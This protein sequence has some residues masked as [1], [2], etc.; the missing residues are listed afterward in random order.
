M[1]PF[2]NPWKPKKNMRLEKVVE[3]SCIGANGLICFSFH[4]DVKQLIGI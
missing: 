4:E 3:K 1:H 2:F